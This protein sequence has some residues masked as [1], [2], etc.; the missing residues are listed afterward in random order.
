M[1]RLF[2][3]NKV[4]FVLSNIIYCGNHHKHVMGIKDDSKIAIIQVKHPHIESIMNE[5]EYLSMTLT[6][7]IMLPELTNQGITGWIAIQP[8]KICSSCMIG[9]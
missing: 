7:S 5:V 2:I 1:S 6:D 4:L 9:L 8:G 3:E